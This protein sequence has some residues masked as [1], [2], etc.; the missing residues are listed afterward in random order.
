MFLLHDILVF[1]KGS[2]IV[3]FIPQHFSILNCKL[4]KNNV[5]GHE[6]GK[7]L[8]QYDYTKHV[9]WKKLCGLER[10]MFASNL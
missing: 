5:K 8:L 6:N 3:V 1:L 2:V 4:I 10:N 7:L 9:V